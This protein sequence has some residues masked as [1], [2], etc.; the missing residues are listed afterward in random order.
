MVCIKF[1]ILQPLFNMAHYE[2]SNIDQLIFYEFI[3]IYWWVFYEYNFSIP[4]MSRSRSVVW[5]YLYLKG[6]SIFIIISLL[7]SCT[8]VNIYKIRYFNILLILPLPITTTHKVD[9]GNMVTI[10]QSVISN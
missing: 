6:A 1:I 7:N 2:Q 4:H 10:M 3:I 8:I 9:S 5:V